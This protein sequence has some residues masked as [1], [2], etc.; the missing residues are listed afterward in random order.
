[1]TRSTTRL[2][3]ALG[4]VLGAAACNNDELF[5][6]ST[7]DPVNPLFTRYA[8]M[9]NSITS[10]FQS[11]GI[12]D[13]TQ[14]QAYPV[15][16]AK[17]MHTPF[18][19]PLLNRPGCT[20]P[21]VAVFANP[22]TY[23]GGATATTCALRE[24]QTPA[25]PYINDVAVPGA[26]AFSV[27]NNL[28]PNQSHANPLTT[29]FLG[30]LTQMQM[31][32]RVNP[33][34]FTAWVGNNDVLNAATSGGDTTL[35]TDTTAFKASYTAMLDSVASPT[36]KGGV[37]IGVANVTLLPFFSKGSTYFAIKAGL[38]PGAAFPPGFIVGPN[39]APN[40]LGGS[41]DSVLVP[42][43]FGIPL[44]GAAAAGA[45]DTLKCTETATVQPAELRRL[46]AT[47]TTYNTFIQAQATAR[48]YAYFDANA[49]FAAV[50]PGSIP[51]FPTISGAASVT[52]PFG[53]YFTR[54]GFHPS[55][56]SHKLVANG[57]IQVINAKYG[58]ALAAIP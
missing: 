56:L 29:F 15:L 39:C 22:R 55:G 16:L 58:T 54:D 46:A 20:P 14:I 53:N 37:L 23:V 38:V 30:G 41:G 19:Q 25:P 52:A 27:T 6:N 57:L 28:D 31:L 9:G 26:Y 40:A 51:P 49:L 17:Q 35:I 48:G 12:N 5:H 34:F 3:A 33:T 32:K 7:Q 50:P 18:W 24:T 13:S 10:G 1:M 45:V 11:G 43:P 8:S 36:L 4:I 47:V 44:V 21:I 42:F 2:M